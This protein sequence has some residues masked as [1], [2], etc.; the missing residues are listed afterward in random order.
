M[1]NKN[2]R[3]IIMKLS[4]IKISNA[5]KEHE[6][7]ESKMEKCRKKFRKGKMDRQIVLDGNGYLI[8]GYVLYKVLEENNYSEDIPVVY[9]KPTTYV[10]GKH[11]GNNKEYIWRV[12]KKY[13]GFDK[14]QGDVVLVHSNGT[15][16]LV[17]ITRIIKSNIP[18]TN[19]R[20]K[21]VVADNDVQ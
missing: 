6:P 14:K 12:P 2:E 9:R 7:S 3:V 5:F 21:T 11:P 16:Q 15:I 19:R 13:K 4:E 20:I 1:N 17:T 10:Y 18:P 8:D